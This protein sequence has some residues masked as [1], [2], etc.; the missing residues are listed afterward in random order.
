M[1]TLPTK[2]LNDWQ[3][4]RVYRQARDQVRQQLITA[5]E[6]AGL[7]I[8]WVPAG[9]GTP[10]CSCFWQVHPRI[11][12]TI[13]PQRSM[14]PKAKGRYREQGFTGECVVEVRCMSIVR[15][16][17]TYY[18]ARRSNGR[19]SIGIIIARVQR[20]LEEVPRAEQLVA[21]S[22]AK[23]ER[24]RQGRADI[25]PFILG[26]NWRREPD[27]TYMLDPLIF[28]FTKEQALE[29]HTVILA[30]VSPPSAPAP[31]TRHGKKN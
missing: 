6:A 18:Y 15:T 21:E 26:A 4:S 7:P 22:T 2:P 16:P 14:M 12:V 29:I 24:A 20:W 13:K 23:D 1:T 17:T 11:R 28:K 30:A 27:G 8:A 19:W 5:A 10:F 3:R 9:P 31:R 25:Q